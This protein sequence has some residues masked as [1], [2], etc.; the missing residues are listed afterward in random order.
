MIS[1]QSSPPM[2]PALLQFAP[3]Q[4]P[5]RMRRVGLP[6]PAQSVPEAERVVKLAETDAEEKE[7]PCQGAPA[8]SESEPALPPSVA[9]AAAVSTPVPAPGPDVA[10]FLAS[11][12]V[13]L[14]HLCAAFEEVGCT[15][16][17]DLHALAA[18]TKLGERLR[19]SLLDAVASDSGSQ[20]AASGTL[21]SGSPKRMSRWD[22][23]ML[24][25]G[26]RELGERQ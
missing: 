23:I 14:S 2:A 11:L 21:A 17:V 22:R 19:A 12:A 1:M 9:Q 5:P 7:G 20:P 16:A 25:E 13:P 8:A 6:S 10:T 26:L 4:S 24:E 3:L 18:R 15:S